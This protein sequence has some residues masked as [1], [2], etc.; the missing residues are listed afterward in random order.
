MKLEDYNDDMRPKVDG[1]WNLYNELPKIELN[2]FIML[3]S[4]VGIAEDP[5]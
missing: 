2:F 3:S 1:I 4:V 5:N